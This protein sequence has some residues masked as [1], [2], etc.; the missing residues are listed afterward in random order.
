MIW[1]YFKI[2]YRSLVRQKTYSLINISGLALGLASFILISVWIINELQYDQFHEKKDR[3]FRLNTVGI[4]Y[5]DNS[6]TP[7][8]SWRLGPALTETYSEIE[9]YSRLWPWSRSLVK[10][11]DKVFIWLIRHSSQSSHF[12]SNMG[13]RIKHLPIST[14]LY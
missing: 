10:Y 14:R 6:V 5:F 2:S 8:S 12:H 4:N 13:H 1:N 11:N 3:I 7:S 9:S